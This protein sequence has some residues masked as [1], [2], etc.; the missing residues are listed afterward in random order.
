MISKA[1]IGQSIVQQSNVSFIMIAIHD[2][3][4]EH[5]TIHIMYDTIP[6]SVVL[7]K[8]QVLQTQS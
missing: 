4:E 6:A 3:K 2:F 8:T 7:P 1:N 5:D